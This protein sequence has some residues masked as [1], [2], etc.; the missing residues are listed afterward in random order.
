[1]KLTVIRLSA[2]GPQD[3]IDLQKIWPE[4]GQHLCCL[5]DTERLYVARFN[6]RLL[7]AVCVSSSGTQG[8]MTR[9]CV[10]EV[11]RRRGVGQY[12]VEEVMRDNPQIPV[13]KISPEGVEDRQSMQAF[14]Q[15]AGFKPRGEGW[16]WHQ[17]D[18]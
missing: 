10:R 1:M 12:L 3:R 15:A 7:G 4:N 16:E 13:W 8:V 17:A 2:P 18:D 11:T 6:N 9:L 5:S 14:A